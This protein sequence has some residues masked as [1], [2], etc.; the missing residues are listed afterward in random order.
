M[1]GSMP[2]IAASTKLTCELGSAPNTVD[3]PENSLAFDSTWQ[4]T[5]RPDDDFPRAGGA[6]DQ[7]G[8]GAHAALHQGCGLAVKF[9]AVSMAR[10]ARNKVASSNALPMS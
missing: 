6:L 5:S 9:A 8:P 10:P 4:W 7:L 2:G 1:T 3:A